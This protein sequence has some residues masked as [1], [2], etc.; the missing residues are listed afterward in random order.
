M[1]K[2]IAQ[3]LYRYFHNK[4]INKV[5]VDLPIADLPKDLNGFKVVHLA[6]IYFQNMTKDNV[7]L[8]QQLGDIQP[9]MIAITGNLIQDDCY[10]SQELI[11]F[12]QGLVNIAPIYIVCGYNEY[13]MSRV[14]GL[15][16][17][18]Q[19]AGARFLMN[20]TYWHAIGKSG[21][22]V[23]GIDDKT[24]HRGKDSLY[25]RRINVPQR[26][27][28]EV[29]VLLAY[30]S[31]WFMHSHP[32]EE[33]LPDVTFSSCDKKD[34]GKTVVRTFFGMGK[35]EDNRYEQ[36][37]YDHPILSDKLLVMTEGGIKTKRLRLRTQDKPQIIVAKFMNK[38]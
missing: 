8:I 36:G 16:R 2:K 9:D 33:Y 3:K 14:D 38:Q 19:K 21:V 28:F 18:I 1:I 7:V 31:E 34:H 10:N 12:I 6:N 22:L 20:D 5:E 25:V 27:A 11:Y 37:V 30:H 15:A 26:Y 35:S 4:R 13:H 17:E 24:A 32:Q 29:K 23:M